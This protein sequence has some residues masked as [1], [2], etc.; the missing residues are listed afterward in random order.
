LDEFVAARLEAVVELA[1]VDLAAV[2]LAAVELAVAVELVEINIFEDEFAV[3]L[4]DEFA[5]EFADNFADAF[6]D[7]F[8]VE[9]TCAV[10][11]LTF[12][13]VAFKV[14]FTVFSPASLLDV[15]FIITWVAFLLRAWCYP[16]LLAFFVVFFKPCFFEL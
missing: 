2:D 11:E 3:A 8:K 7:E 16:F 1:A 14:P 4:A 12:T 9:F 13:A 6:D 15:E 10:D 5:V